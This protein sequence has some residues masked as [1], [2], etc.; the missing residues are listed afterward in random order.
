MA[1]RK[2]T[3]PTEAELEILNIL[4]RDG[5]STVRQVQH[6]LNAVRPTGYTT[7]LKFLQLMIDKELVLRDD[8]GHAHIYRAKA[9]QQQT[10]RQLLG[11]LMERGFGGSAMQLAMQALSLQKVSSEEVAQIRT[12]LDQLEKDNS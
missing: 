1:R 10:Q 4:W 3:Q 9:P 2:Q 6:Q 7:A 8:S 11:D 5:P 12:L